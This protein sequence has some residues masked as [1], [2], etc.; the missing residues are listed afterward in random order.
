[1]NQFISKKSIPDILSLNG[2]TPT[3]IKK[4][5]LKELEVNDNFE[6]TVDI[7]EFRIYLEITNYY[8]KRG[9]EWTVKKVK[10]HVGNGT[11]CL[12]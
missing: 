1:M 3:R 12:C 7:E 9:R 11:Y 2:Y 6:A 5:L 8:H 10:Q 4:V